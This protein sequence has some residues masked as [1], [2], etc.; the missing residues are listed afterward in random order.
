MRQL[1]F[2]LFIV[3]L[4]FLLFEGCTSSEKSDIPVVNIPKNVEDL[5]LDEFGKS[6][7]YVHL[8]TKPGSFISNILDIKKFGSYLLIRD[9]SGKVLIFTDDG[10]FVKKLGEIGEGPGEY[11]NAYSL[12][13]NENLGIIYLGSARKIQMYSKNFEFINEIKLSYFA[14]YLSVNNDDLL[15]ITNNDSEKTPSGYISNTI[16]YKLDQSLQLKDSTLLRSVLIKDNEL[17]GFTTQLFIS[18]TGDETFLYTP[19]FYDEFFLRDTLYQIKSNLIVPK[20]KFKFVDFNFS[21]KGEKNI[22]ITNIVSSKSYYIC[23]YERDNELMFF[24]YNKSKNMGFHTRIGLIDK[25]GEAQFIFPLDLSDD[26]F[27]FIIESE[28]FSSDKEELNPTIGIVELD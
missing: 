16:L 13:V 8:E 27:Y 20:T 2:K 3:A 15:L 14:N 4:L 9:K 24:I 26:R 22:S 21:D 25:F 5:Y 17:R 7:E 11:V 1:N 28:F 19:V 6:I 23:Q 12:A 18:N 10:K